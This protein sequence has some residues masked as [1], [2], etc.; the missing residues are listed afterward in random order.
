MLSSRVAKEDHTWT[1]DDRSTC[2]RVLALAASGEWTRR[3]RLY[4]SRLYCK[5]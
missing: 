2:D 5:W 1:V 3:A 4:D